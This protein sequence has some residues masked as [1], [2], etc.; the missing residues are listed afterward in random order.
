MKTFKSF[1]T[2]GF[3]LPEFTQDQIKNETMLFN[4][5]GEFALKTGGI[6]TNQFLTKFHQETGIPYK[7][8]VVDTRSHT[9]MKNWF[10]CIPG[11]HHDDVA[12]G[13][14][15]QP[16]YDNMP[17]KAQHCL[18]LV[19]GD[20]CP[21]EFAIGT[22]PFNEVPEGEIVYKQWHKEVT[23]YIRTGKLQSVSAPSNK[24]VYFNWETWHQGTKC[25]KPGWRWFGRI[26]WET[27]RKPTNEIR[28]QVN[29]YLEFPMEGW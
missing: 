13:K 2:V 9:L 28:R 5:D 29:V 19:N 22:T 8:I 23:E 21:T 14:N 20:I 24:L 4:C 11:F 25:I 26:S 3:D 6:I 12:R 17:Y 10:P 18:A 16:D 1:M 7:K 27:E 15:G